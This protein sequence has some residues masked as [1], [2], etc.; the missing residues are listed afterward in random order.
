MAEKFP[1]TIYTPKAMKVLESWKVKFNKG[2]YLK[3]SNINQASV[4]E[5]V[6]KCGIY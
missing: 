6:R 5:N 3:P 4:S 1:W 2:Q